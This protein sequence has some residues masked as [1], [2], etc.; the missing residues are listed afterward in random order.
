M[1]RIRIWATALSLIVWFARPTAGAPPSP[2][3]IDAKAAVL[4]DAVTGQVLFEQ[5]AT[6]RMAPASLVKLMTIY[7]AYD[8]LEAGSVRQNDLVSISRQAS[9]MGGSQIFLQ[10]GDQ[11]RF[12]ELLHGLA[13]A[14]GNDAAVALAEH[15]AGFRAAFV[16]Q[17]NAKAKELELNDTN[18][19]NPNGLPAPDQLTT[20]R[21]MA[22]LALHLIRDHPTTLKVH[23]GKTFEYRGIRQH[24]RNR[25]IWK[26]SRVDGLKTGWLEEA[27]YHIVAT[28]KEGDRRLIAVVLG[29]DS[30]RGRE[31]IALNMLNYGFK[32]F[33]NVRFFAQGDR[34]KNLP[35]W[36][37]NEDLIGV[38]AKEPGIVTIENGSPPPTLAYHFPEKLVAPI[39]AGQKVGQ[40]L[41]T[42][43]G[44]EIARVD[45][46]AMTAVPQAGFLKRLFHSLLLVFY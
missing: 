35:V 8:A 7:L 29:A 27:G 20:A 2:F 13:I 44:R 42:E 21:D 31:E 6:T 14:S 33:H 3:Q 26:D 32:N 43:E 22:F 46:I 30:E 1:S 4:L 40:A 41:I 10:E 24:N 16:A 5:N 37:G 11:V 38:V 18:F 36:K 15:L 12:A 45:L 17:M 25:L 23:S 34:V 39:P 19:Q 28:A 9:K